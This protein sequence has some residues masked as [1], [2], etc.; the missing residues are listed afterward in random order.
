MFYSKRAH[1]FSAK[2]KF[3]SV[4]SVVNFFLILYLPTKKKINANIVTFNGEFPYVARGEGENGIRGY[5][6]FD[7]KFLNPSNTISFGQ[8]TVTM[9]YQ[10]NAYFT[11]DKIQIFKLN[12]K[13]G[14][15][16]EN[17][18][19]YLISS[20]KKAFTNFSWGQSS[21]AL[22]VISNIDIELPVTKSGTI[23]FEYMEKY[24]QVIKKQLIEDVVEYKDEYIS[25]SKSTVFK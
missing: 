3:N 4:V 11:G 9:Y 21:F 7:E 24:I 17:I 1:H 19:L 25:K 23:D 2:N 20:M 22:D 12:K 14:K 5:I 18:A 10:P 6:D 13:Y 15:L 8:D 16:T